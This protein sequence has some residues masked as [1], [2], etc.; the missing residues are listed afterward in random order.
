[1]QTQRES[2][3]QELAQ[4][5]QQIQQ[6]KDLCPNSYEKMR[7]WQVLTSKRHNIL[8]ELAVLSYIESKF[9]TAVQNG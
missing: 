6:I 4:V 5:D 8:H 9:T 7:T 3:K 1:M 2:L